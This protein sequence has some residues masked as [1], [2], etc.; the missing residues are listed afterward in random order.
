MPKKTIRFWVHEQWEDV[1]GNVKFRILELL[2]AGLG[3]LIARSTITQLGNLTRGL[4]PG[5]QIWLPALFVMFGAATASLAWI[6]GS[7][8]GRQQARRLALA[9]VPNLSTVMPH[10]R[11]VYL[12]DRKIFVATEPIQYAGMPRVDEFQALVLGFRNDAPTRAAHQV[13][14][15]LIYHGLNYP[16]TGCWVDE[17]ADYVDFEPNVAS[18]DV[19]LVLT[20]ARGITSVA[21]HRRGSGGK[22]ALDVLTIAGPEISGPDAFDLGIELSSEGSILKQVGVAV[23]LRPFVRASIR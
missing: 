18:Q 22:G 7:E 13:R 3:V 4:S 20:D 1:K 17:A 23:T 16:L 19:I 2:L 8:R 6:I 21:D 9:N 15:K 5:Q 10:L 11:D 12:V 14:A